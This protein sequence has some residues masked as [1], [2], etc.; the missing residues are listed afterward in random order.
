MSEY[1]ILSIYILMLLISYNADKMGFGQQSFLE[2]GVPVLE[3]TSNRLRLTDGRVRTR[4]NENHD[5]TFNSRT[6]QDADISSQTSDAPLSETIH[7]WNNIYRQ[8][9]I[10]RHRSI[11]TGT[12]AFNVLANSWKLA[13]YHSKFRFA[14]QH[15]VRKRDRVQQFK[16]KHHNLIQIWHAT[17]A[18]VSS[19]ADFN[20]DSLDSNK[21]STHN[22]SRRSSHVAAYK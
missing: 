16:L 21:S 11:L 19:F 6:R 12:R 18:I 7:S 1:Q 3:N 13:P 17:Y 14:I 8:P 20:L 4:Q 5:S 9:W 2:Q 10:S 22:K 15:A